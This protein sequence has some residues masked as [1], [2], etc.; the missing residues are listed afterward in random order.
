MFARGAALCI[1]LLVPSVVMAQA[2]LDLVPRPSANC[3]NP[4]GVYDFGEAVTVD[5][6]LS[7]TSG[8]VHHLRMIQF[9][10]SASDGSLGIPSS[11]TWT[12]STNHFAHSNGSLLSNTY[13]GD[14]ITPALGLNS[15][16]QFTLPADG[17][18][19]KVGEF[20]VMMPM[21]GGTF[22]LDAI[23]VADTSADGGGQIRFG[24]SLGAPTETITVW[25]NS[26]GML[27]G[28]SVALATVN[29]PVMGADPIDGGSVTAIKAN[30]VDVMF[31]R[32]LAGVDGPV[33]LEGSV[34]IRAL[35]ADCGLGP[36]LAPFGNF[37]YEFMNSGMQLRISEVAD[38][39]V[40]SHQ[41][42]YAV[43]STGSPLPPFKVDFV[44]MV[45]DVDGNLFTAFTDIPLM[46]AVGVIDTVVTDA[47]RRMDIDG[48]GFIAFTDIPLL[49]VAGVIDTAAPDKPSGHGCGQ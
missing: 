8:I 40:L 31:N 3:F 22:M 4:C 38:P 42:W 44:N 15:T 48:N 41:T 45:G 46:L 10:F 49:L 27:N 11:A 20:T 19:V 18:A 13:H 32:T 34:E 5:A 12:A 47:T 24:Y 23:N 9:D 26:N 37:T 21:S 39:G 33:N 30:V 17:S 35:L 2:T 7:H 25:R 28:G 36:D 29:Q 14:L 43:V 6:M 16:E 1:S